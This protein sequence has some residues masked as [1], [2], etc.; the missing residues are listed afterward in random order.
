[1]YIHSF[2]HSVFQRSIIVDIEL[3]IRYAAFSLMMKIAHHNV[4]FS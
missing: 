1:M 4:K 2:I 3:V